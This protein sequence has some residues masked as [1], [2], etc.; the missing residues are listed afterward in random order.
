MPLES[1]S[2]GPRRIAPVSRITRTN[3]DWVMISLGVLLVCLFL[4]TGYLSLVPRGNAT[5]G[6]LRGP[7][8]NPNALRL[9]NMPV[10]TVPIQK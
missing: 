1:K 7:V 6:P 8:K 2:T 9:Q 4:V 5:G 3:R 10:E